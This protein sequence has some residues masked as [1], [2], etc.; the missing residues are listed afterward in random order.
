[1]PQRAISIRAPL[2]LLT[3]LVAVL[4]AVMLAAVPLAAGAEDPLAHITSPQPGAVVRDVVVI[5]GSAVH[6][7]F[8]FYKVEFAAEP[9]TNWSVIGDTHASQVKDGALAQWNTQAVPDGSYSLRLTVVDQTGNYMESVVRQV[10]VANAAAAQSPTPSESPTADGTLTPTATPT[11]AGTPAPTATVGVV[12]PALT[13]TVGPTSTRIAATT[14]AETD[15][16]ATTEEDSGTGGLIKEMLG[17]VVKEAVGAIGIDF[18]GLG[19]ATV[20]GALLALAI[21]AVVGVLALLRA[22]VVGAYR[23][24]R[25]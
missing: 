2:G 11:V 20:R 18:S 1:M 22:I 21:F 8:S 5:T 7:A 3:R 17:G 24:I 9:G 19:G 15:V 23:L 6:P 16:P 10:V 14:T 12:I 4:A 25:R 13:V